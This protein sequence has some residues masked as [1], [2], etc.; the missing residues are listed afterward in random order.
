MPRE[1]SRQVI[2]D[3]A[4][5][6]AS[7]QG[8]D[9]LSIGGLAVAVGMSK[10][11][12]CAHFP[13]KADLQAAAVERAAEIFRAAVVVPAF[14]APAGLPRL[15]A[16]AE[17]W[18]RYLEAE[19]FEGGCF[20]TNALLELDQLDDVAAKAAVAGHYQRFLDLLE[21]LAGE[22]GA[23]GELAPGSDPRDLAF[24][25]HGLQLATLTGRSLGRGEAA[26]ALGRARTAA[27]LARS[28]G[29]ET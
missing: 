8:L 24:E 9:G 1:S 10:G 6:L 12:V 7:A 3:R 17:A 14:A 21:A 11:G 28:A 26:L 29:T 23:R 18:F 19:T 15:Q 4:V 20:F 22:A 27:L 25:L 5:Q 16:L 2:L 13:T